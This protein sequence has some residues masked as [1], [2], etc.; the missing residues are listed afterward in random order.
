MGTCLNE[1]Y[2]AAGPGLIA[3]DEFGLNR[4]RWAEIETWRAR[5]FVAGN[6]VLWVA[7]EIPAGLRIPLPPSP[8]PAPAPIRPLDLALPGYQITGTGGVGISMAGPRSFAA[9]LTLDIMQRRLT[10]VLRHELGVSYM[11]L[12]TSDPCD[13]EVSHGWL[14]ADALP[15]QVS[16]AAHSALTTIEDLAD[17]GCKPEEIEEYT[18]RYRDLHGSPAGV[19]ARLNQSAENVLDAR[20]SYSQDE[21]VRQITCISPRT[22]GDTARAWYSRAIVATP[23]F[24]PAVQGRMPR[25]PVSST[26]AVP[27]RRHSGSRPGQVLTVGDEGVTLARHAGQQVTVRYQDIAAALCWTDHK[28]ALVGRDGFVIQLDP[29]EWPAGQA[30]VT[31]IAG[32]VEPGLMVDMAGPGPAA[33]APSPAPAPAARPA[34]TPRTVGGWVAAI[35]SV[36]LWILIVLCALAG[37][38]ALVG[39]DSSAWP[40]AVFGVAGACWRAAPLIYWRLHPGAVPQRHGWW[41]KVIRGCLVTWT[42]V[43]AILLASGDGIA[44]VLAL[45]GTAALALQPLAASYRHRRPL[46][47]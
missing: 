10:R 33:R 28:L 4:L 35:W 39:H 20:P 8:A 17:S 47:G 11:V 22:V 19:I 18:R 32:R 9:S 41:F 12:G 38:I 24:L 31:S 27:G 36:T 3:Y 21:A 44:G 46:P 42:V 30:L 45:A 23:Q 37:V 1:R 43:C 40:L 15:D 29:A 2:G 16:L 14:F 26:H 34:R 7:G 25:L 13:A 5:W 6:A